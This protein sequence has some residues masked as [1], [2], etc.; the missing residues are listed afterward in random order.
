MDKT[1]IHLDA[2][3]FFASVEQGHNPMLTGRPVIVGG[4]PHQRGCVHTA[5]YDAR[6]RGVYTG[7]SLRQ[8]QEICPDAVFLK[9]DYRR[10]RAASAVIE[11]VLRTFSPDVELASLD[12]AYVD[13]T[14]VLRLYPSAVDAAAQAQKEIRRRL[15]IGVSVGIATSKLVA[16]VAS[17]LNK[18]D[19]ITSVP[20]GEERR[21]LSVLPLRLLRGIG[22]KTESIFRELGITTIGALLTLPKNTV[23]QLLGGAVGEM[24]WQYAQ[25]NDARPVEQKTI[26]RQVSRETSFGEDSDDARL[27]G[28]TLRYL[29]ERIAAKLRQNEWTAR[30]IFLKVYYADGR[31]QKQSRTLPRRTNDGSFIGAQVRALYDGF[32]VRRVRVK[33]VG[34]AVSG[35]APVE[36][37][38]SMFDVT[39]RQD[40][41]NAG[42]DRVR[43]RYGFTSLA[44]ADTLI[45]QN[46]YRME[47]HGFVLH[48]P[49]L[50]Q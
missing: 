41:L 21:F 45:L 19:G 11:E 36:E 4:L 6:R 29:A 18:P 14:G 46:Y 2:D 28:G 5:S 8:A 50:S 7:M 1:I 16:R 20:P 26:P 10:Y 15:G 44:S 12:D 38:R 49:A 32:P 25:G 43:S 27:I 42:V 17:G 39:G 9:G 30:R 24:I 48:T 35:I 34:A 22:P 3:A 23:L 37:Q 33:L 13:M 40:E 47:S 31:V